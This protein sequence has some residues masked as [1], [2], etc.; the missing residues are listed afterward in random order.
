M[1]D[2]MVMERKLDGDEAAKASG[3]PID[4]RRPMSGKERSARWRCTKQTCETANSDAKMKDLAKRS[5]TRER[6]SERHG[7]RR[8]KGRVKARE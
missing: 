7:A 6:D 8:E 2:G 1:K 4:W 3:G 5:S